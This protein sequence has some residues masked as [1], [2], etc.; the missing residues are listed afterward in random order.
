MGVAGFLAAVLLGGLGS[1][2]AS[3][4]AAHY[5]YRSDRRRRAQALRHLDDLTRQM[6]SLKRPRPVKGPRW[7]AAPYKR[8]FVPA[9]LRLERARSV[10]RDAQSRQG[11]DEPL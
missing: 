2:V 7:Q 11:E 5:W 6:Q 8:Y 1:H 10:I 9:G 3:R 4:A